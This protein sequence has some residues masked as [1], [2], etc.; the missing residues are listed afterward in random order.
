MF[1][2]FN[3]YSNGSKIFLHCFICLNSN[4]KYEK[5]INMSYNKKNHIKIQ[6]LTK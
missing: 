3:M 6:Y 1:T 5:Q 2:C 4:Y